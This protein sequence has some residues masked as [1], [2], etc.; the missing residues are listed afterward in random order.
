MPRQPGRRGAVYAWAEQG[1]TLS[2]RLRDSARLL[3]ELD[4]LDARDRTLP[5]RSE[6]AR[7]AETRDA[8]SAEIE[9]L[10]VLVATDYGISSREVARLA[11]VSKNSVLRWVADWRHRSSRAV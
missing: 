8:I 10:A 4:R 2:E 11:G 9:I 5:A 1:P 7:L 6:L 3:D